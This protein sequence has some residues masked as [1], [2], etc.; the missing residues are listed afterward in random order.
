MTY[1]NAGLRVF[2]ISDPLQPTEVAY[3]VP[4]DPPVRQGPKPDKLVTQFE[5]VLVDHRGYVFC[6]DKNRGL[7]V[8]EHTTT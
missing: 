7:F 6:T 3:F 2:D 1:F 4:D 5:D 8:I